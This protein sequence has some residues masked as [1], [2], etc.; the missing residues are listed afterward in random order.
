MIH[1]PDSTQLLISEHL[2]G[3]MERTA[4]PAGPAAERQHKAVESAA[5]AP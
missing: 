5:N 3:E 2:R 1:A 4:A